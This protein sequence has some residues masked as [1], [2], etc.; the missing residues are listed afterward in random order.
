MDVGAVYINQQACRE[1]H[2]MLVF[3]FEMMDDQKMLS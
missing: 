2:M 3:Y 1:T